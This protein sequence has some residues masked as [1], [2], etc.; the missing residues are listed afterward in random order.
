MIFKNNPVLIA[1][2]DVIFFGKKGFATLARARRVLVRFK[3]VP[4]T[5]PWNELDLSKYKTKAQKEH[6]F[7]RFLQKLTR[8][9]DRAKREAERKKAKKRKP[10]KKIKVKRVQRL[11][12]EERKPKRVEELDEEEIPEPVQK[13]VVDFKEPIISKKAITTRSGK[14]VFVTKYDFFLNKDIKFTEGDKYDVSA[15][16]NFIAAAKQEFIKVYKEHGHKDY[17]IKVFHNYNNM[18]DYYDAYP[19]ERPPAKDGVEVADKTFGGMSLHRD[20]FTSLAQINEQFDVV[21]NR[22]YLSNFSSYLNF[23]NPST[24]FKFSGFMIEVSVKRIKK[25]KLRG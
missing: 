17:L 21:L 25:V 23:A 10:K 19:K 2:F 5:T 12:E 13:L 9:R 18:V 7:F 22:K 15:A 4:K 24:Q 8:A 16:R 20:K 6:V 14:Q 11:K 1:G 3:G